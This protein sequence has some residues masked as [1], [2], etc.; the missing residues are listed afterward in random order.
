MFSKI[1]SMQ[2]PPGRGNNC[3]TSQDLKRQSN[4]NPIENAQF[5]WY[6]LSLDLWNMS[7]I[8]S[9]WYFWPDNVSSWRI[10]VR[11]VRILKGKVIGIQLKMLHF[12]TKICPDLTWYFFTTCPRGEIK[13]MYSHVLTLSKTSS[14]RYDKSRHGSSSRILGSHQ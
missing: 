8:L 6:I 2:P 12:I 10:I 1:S 3:K 4:W 9:T 14:L 11:P 5:L 13:D 7:S